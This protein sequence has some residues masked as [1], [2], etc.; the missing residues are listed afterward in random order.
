VPLFHV[1]LYEGRG[2]GKSAITCLQNGGCGV[3]P[4]ARIV[5]TRFHSFRSI[6]DQ[7]TLLKTSRTKRK[8]VQEWNEE[9]MCSRMLEW[10][11]M[12]FKGFAEN[13]SKIHLITDLMA[14]EEKNAQSRLLIERMNA[15]WS[16]E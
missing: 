1:D 12:G 8:C 2:W 16:S 3:Q 15:F 13:V 6:F 10:K 7:N 4:D 11:E 14:D 5:K 9:K